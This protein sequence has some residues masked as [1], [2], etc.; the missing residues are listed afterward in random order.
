MGQSKTLLKKLWIKHIEPLN[1]RPGG[2]AVLF[3]VK[4]LDGFYYLDELE[5]IPTPTRRGETLF[6]LHPG[7]VYNAQNELVNVRDDGHWTVITTKSRNGLQL[8]YFDPLYKNNGLPREIIN[9]LER[10]GLPYIIDNH[11]PQSEFD[12][13]TKSFRACGL[14]CIQFI[15]KLFS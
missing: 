14:Y 12:S 9:Y 2:G 5:Y 3:G 7:A 8:I 15:K 11:S 1:K 4:D 13:S 10:S 6:I